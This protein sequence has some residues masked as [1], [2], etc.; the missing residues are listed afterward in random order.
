[1]SSSSSSSTTNN[2]NPPHSKPDQTQT[3]QSEQPHKPILTLPA[4]EDVEPGM[5]LEVNGKD[6]KLDILGPVVVNE[7]GTMSRIDN[8][9]EMAEIEKANVR[10]ILLKRND[11]RLKRLRA[12]RD[13]EIAQ[14]AASNNS[15]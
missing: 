4:P 12:K 6:I 5:S 8:W 7:D 11:L 10:R 2:N 14:E 9:A 15:E 3:D 13:A 1:M